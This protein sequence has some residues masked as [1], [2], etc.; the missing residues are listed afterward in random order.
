M[1]PKSIGLESPVED[2]GLSVRTRNALRGVGCGTV[3]DVLGLNLASPVRGLGRKTKDELLAALERCGY[4]HPA[5]E[6]Q[7]PSD[8]R[9]LE[10]SLERMQVRVEAAL[11]AVTREI[12]LVKLRLRKSAT[13]RPK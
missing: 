12:E 9:V 7:P 3:R 6:R 5:G 8:I 10:R 1:A 11:G 13:K 2:L 4:H